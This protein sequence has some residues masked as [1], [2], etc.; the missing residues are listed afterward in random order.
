MKAL[1]VSKPRS[2]RGKLC[3]AAIFLLLSVF[4]LL[5]ILGLTVFR[6]RHAVTV[7]NSV[8]L[9]GVRA[10]FNAP[11]LGVDVNATLLLD[12]SVTNP[13][14]AGFRYPDGGTAELYY[15]GTLVGEAA[16]PPGEIG[17]EE[18]IQMNVTLTVMA[19]RLIADSNV[20]SDV[21]SGSLPLTTYTK[22]AGRVTVMG[23][24]KHHVVTS[25]TCDVVVNISTQTLTN[26]DCKY[27][28][29]L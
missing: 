27:K 6:P 14:R 12:I 10:G 16:I 26:S 7:V 11:A 20:Y 19:G 9:T 15:R 5:L 22:I 24:F 25:T 8:R 29:K 28:T 2:K 18:T 3:A 21:L 4:L 17:T 13:N 1:K 23:W